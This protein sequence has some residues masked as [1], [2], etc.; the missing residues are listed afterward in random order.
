MDSHIT[1]MAF[2]CQPVA[3][4]NR[5]AGIMVADLI[6]TTGRM[7]IGR[8]LISVMGLCSGVFLGDMTVAPSR[9]SRSRKTN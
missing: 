5:L 3:I 9:L 1:K 4:S 2:R 6:G 7:Q 8:R